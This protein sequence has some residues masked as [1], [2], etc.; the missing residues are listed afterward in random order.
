MTLSYAAYKVECPEINRKIFDESS[1]IFRFQ[2]RFVFKMI[3]RAC[4]TIGLMVHWLKYR[5]SLLKIFFR[6]IKSKRNGRSWKT[7]IGYSWRG[8]A[9][10]ETH[11][12]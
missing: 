5:E 1:L 9:T 2:F 6:R 8:N 3:I 7:W 4:A 10:L 11:L 12:S